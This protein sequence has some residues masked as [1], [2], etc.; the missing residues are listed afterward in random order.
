LE[1]RGTKKNAGIGYVVL[2][3]QRKEKLKGNLE[4]GVWNIGIGTYANAFHGPHVEKNKQPFT[5]KR[6][7]VDAAIYQQAR[8]AR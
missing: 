5:I 1:N 3:K 2:V 7:M 6:C 4:L 8:L